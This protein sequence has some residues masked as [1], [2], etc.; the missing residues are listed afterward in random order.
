MAAASACPAVGAPCAPCDEQADVELEIFLCATAFAAGACACY[1]VV[2]LR[3]PAAADADAGPKHGVPWLAVALYAAIPAV[4]AFCINSHLQMRVL[5]LPHLREQLRAAKAFMGSVLDANL[6]GKLSLAE[7]QWGARAPIVVDTQQAFASSEAQWLQTINGLQVSIRSEVTAIVARHEALS[8]G[9]FVTAFVL[10]LVL[11]YVLVL[12]HMGRDLLPERSWLARFLE[13]RGA[14]LGWL[15]CMPVGLLG[16][17][18]MYV[19]QSLVS[20]AIGVASAMANNVKALR[21]VQL[22]LI[23]LGYDKQLYNVLGTVEVL[24]GKRWGVKIGVWGGGYRLDHVF[25]SHFVFW[26]IFWLV[27]AFVLPMFCIVMADSSR[28]SKRLQQ[29]E[30]SAAQARRSAALAQRSVGFVVSLDDLRAL[31]EDQRAGFDD[32]RSCNADGSH[33]H[34]EAGASR[35]AW[36]AVMRAA[37]KR[38]P[39]AIKVLNAGAADAAGG[40]VPASAAGGTHAAAAAELTSE[41]KLFRDMNHPHIVDCWGI[42]SDPRGGKCIVTELCKSPLHVHLKREAVWANKTMLQIDTEKLRILV[43][44][45]KGMSYMHREVKV[46][47]KDIKT[48]NI[49]LD[50]DGHRWKIC[51][52]GESKVLPDAGATFTPT[53]EEERSA[54]TST[55]AAP[56]LMGGEDIGLPADCFAFGVVVWE[57][58]TRLSAWQQSYGAFGTGTNLFN[59]WYIMDKVLVENQRLPIPQGPSHRRPFSRLGLR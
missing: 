56:E 55:I 31:K 6:D 5:L 1:A 33:L 3:R 30:R 39:V 54:F 24:A 18:Q 15:F 40:K 47:H 50:G 36:G 59:E 58:L 57:V 38:E 4:A 8:P 25:W 44:V 13:P 10:T 14:N 41:M 46:L 51:D 28:K 20:V 27:A 34:D 9:R 16:L 7:V 11:F 35:G 29:S 17:Y 37:W 12:L 49:L 53:S 23:E 21:K 48:A 2:A 19:L 32:W 45:V 43:H 52:F 42:V 22:K 26:F